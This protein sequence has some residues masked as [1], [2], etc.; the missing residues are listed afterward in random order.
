MTLKTLI[1]ALA[2]TS[3][4]ATAGRAAP[5]VVVIGFDGADW[6]ITRQMMERGELPHLAALA[7]E[8]GAWPLLPTNPPQTPVSWSTFATGLNPGRTEIFDFIKKKDRGYLPTLCAFDEKPRQAFLFGER[9]RLALALVGATVGLVP[10][11]FALAYR[12]RRKPLAI[13]AAAVAALGAAGGF[14]FGALLPSSVPAPRNNR[15]GTPFW[16]VA[17][18]HGLDCRIL[19]VPVTFP[20]EDGD[21]LEMLSGLGV[22]DI[23]GLNGQPTVYT[24]REGAKGE[25]FSVKVVRIPLVGATPVAT[26][27]EGPKNLLFP[28][29]ACCLTREGAETCET[30]TQRECAEREGEYLGDQTMCVEQGRCVRP[31][32]AA[33]R[34][35]IPMRLAA[36]GDALRIEAGD[37]ASVVAPGAWSDWHVFEFEFNPLIAAKG[38]ARFYNQS[39]PGLTELAMSPVHIH[40]DSGALAGF[41]HPDDYSKRLEDE[42]GLYKTMGWASDTW[43]VG[44]ELSTEQQALEDINFTADSFEELMKAELARDTDLF[45]QV[46]A[47]TDRTQHV[48]WRLRDTA[49]PHHDP[50]LAKRYENVIPDA[51]RRMDAMVGTARALAPQSRFFVCSDHGFASFRRGVN[52]NRWLVD[53]DYMVLEHDPCEATSGT[54]RSLDDLFERPTSMFSEVD[55]SQTRAFAMGLGNVYVNLAGREPQGIVR[56]GDDYE[57]LLAEIAT[58]LESLVDPGN[59]AKPV[60]KVH[61][62]DEMYSGYDPE[63]V[64]DL[65]VSN[66]DGYRVSWDT[67][68][69]GIPCEQIVDNMKPWSG[70]HCSVE[71]E[72]VKGILFSSVPLPQAQARAPEMADM[73]P[74]ILKALGLDVP[75]GLDGEP[76]M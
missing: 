37:R 25:Q 58:G 13:A 24:S 61:R 20:A 18:Q 6:N 7:K 72:L 16:Q 48:F 63:L 34:I 38:M 39:G 62:R 23:R 2:L 74:T 55:W 71:P 3:L 12:R 41:C 19:Q 33:P 29:G 15:K 49:H 47:F 28:E 26:T 30:L 17:Q 50:A 42:V 60:A 70:D 44:D 9:N 32:A 67:V 59:G 27:I 22:P 69:G 8:G 31:P 76:L 10:L 56:P 52:I 65:R 75:A 51:Y 1:A 46:F 35:A 54:T 66:T 43:T 53:H 45:V 11:L 4:A 14:A 64:P 73:A 40:P 36:E 57:N 68:L 5:K 21:R